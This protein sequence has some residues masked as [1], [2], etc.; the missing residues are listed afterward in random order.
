M[1]QGPAEI[2]VI[3]SL[4]DSDLGIFAA[5]RG[6]A[7]S[8]QRAININAP[9]AARLLD[10]GL[11]AGGGTTLDCL[12][13]FGA[14]QERSQRAFL[15]VHKNW[16]L[17]GHKLS[18]KA[19]AKLDSADFAI[20]RSVEANTG[21]NP[22]TLTFISRATDPAAHAAIS[23]ML[24]GKLDRSVLTVDEVDELFKQ[25]SPHA[26][27]LPATTPV[28]TA[29]PGTTGAAPAAKQETLKIEPMPRDPGPQQARKRTIKE[30]LR[31]PSIM[32]RMLRVAGDLSAPA[33]LEFMETVEQLASQLREVLLATGRIVKIARDHGAFWPKVRGKPIGFVDGGLANLVSLG[34]AP[35]ACRVGGYLVTP[36]MHGNEREKFSTLK[37][38][39]SELYAAPG[40]GVYRGG[41]PDSGALRDAA[42][43]SIEAAGGVRMLQ[44]NPDM[45]WLFLHGA[46]VNPVSRYTDVMYQERVVHPFPEFS[47]T[48]LQELLPAGEARRRGRD[49]NFISVH[50]RQL[51]LLQSSNAVVCGVIERE[52]S[53]SS[54]I[55]AVLASL[56]DEVIRPLLPRPP[57]EWKRWFRTSVDPTDDEES[58][59]QR[60]TDSLLFRC[61]LEAGEALL[62]VEIDRNEMRRAPRAWH[63]EIGNYPR[64]IV[65]YVQPT[66]WNA[67]VR[68]EMFAKDSGRFT[69]TAALL[70]HCAMLLPKYAF[71]VGLDI[72][73]K[74]AKIPNW[75]SRPVNTHTAV[76]A[77][78]SAL[79]RGDEKL[80]DNLRR[81]L[82]G[83]SREW[84]TRPGAF[85]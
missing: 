20:I 61:V 66:E 85:R 55:R 8:K 63:T 27:A 67:P 41:F 5:H 4:T 38:L 36:G 16:R 12:S 47:D 52:S 34:S 79:E 31:T 32:E 30:K 50:L 26:L 2:L 33:Q 78:K 54:V 11:Y 40:G 23:Q 76:I 62:P 51:Q 65:S 75:M 59:G 83:T 60:I 35:I 9:A 46:L 22:I 14:I 39:I 10:A 53:T 18:G 77:L 56:D 21:Q 58:E 13:A 68:L 48:A 71:P 64:P 82:C 37:L 45:S 42:R 81:V 74:F 3:R 17:G 44:E 29:V 1:T 7:R 73:D 6:S 28:A 15:K 49:A 19:Y 24:T 70:M 72:V 84:I 69:D 80:F 43:I 57:E 25:L